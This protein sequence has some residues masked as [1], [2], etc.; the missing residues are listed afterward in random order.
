MSSLAHSRS[1]RLS[2]WRLRLPVAVAVALGIGASTAKAQ[3]SVDAVVLEPCRRSCG[4]TLVPEREYGADSGEEMIEAEIA[5]GRLDASGRAYVIAGWSTPHVWVFGADGGLLSRIG[6]FGSGPGEFGDISSIVVTEDGVFSVLDRGRGAIMTFDWT[7]ELLREVRTETWLPLGFETLPLDGSLVLHVADIQT[8]A[9]VG[10]PIHVV[11]LESGT[12]RES[13]GSRTGEYDLGNRLTSRTIARGPGSSIWMAPRSGSYQVELWE[14]NT[15]VRVLRRDVEWFPPDELGGHGWEEKPGPTV[16][17]IASDDSLLWVFATTAD[18]RWAEAGATRDW[19]L[20][21]DTRIEVIDWQRG[22][23]LASERFD[24][25][26]DGWVEPGL[27]GNL[28][29]TPTGSVRYVIYR[30]QLEEVSPP[31][32]SSERVPR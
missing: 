12:I 20:F 19:D 15:L 17:Y 28:V 10:Y 1:R 4:L 27:I 21:V 23:V 18:E 9:Q 7:G 8:P 25:D 14:S 30:V 22:R 6:R 3:E 29:V 32:G 26:Y 2:L 11:D 5:I 24:E 16:N 31:S 13:F